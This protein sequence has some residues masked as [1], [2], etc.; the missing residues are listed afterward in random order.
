MGK[1]GPGVVSA[2]SLKCISV[3]RHHY[4]RSPE[5][6]HGTEEVARYRKEVIEKHPRP[7]VGASAEK[8]GMKAHEKTM[9][10][11]QETE[12]RNTDDGAKRSTSGAKPEGKEG[13]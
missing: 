12:L 11:S 6:L 4:S 8:D 3:E 7:K 5:Q 9:K 2:Y 10:S 1:K 13:A